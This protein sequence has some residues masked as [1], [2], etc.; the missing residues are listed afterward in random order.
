M[1]DVNLGQCALWY[2]QEAS[3]KKCAASVWIFR[4]AVKFLSGLTLDFS[5]LGTWIS[6]LIFVTCISYIHNQM[7]LLCLVKKC[8]ETQLFLSKLRW[9][10]SEILPSL[11]VLLVMTWWRW[12]LFFFLI[13]RGCTNEVEART[14]WNSA[15]SVKISYWSEVEIISNNVRLGWY[16]FSLD[17]MSTPVIK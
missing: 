14:L 13:Y 8:R 11:E 3:W 15:N 17:W 9:P 6:F 2:A 4:A 12:V 10:I 16:L 5:D 7:V 1:F